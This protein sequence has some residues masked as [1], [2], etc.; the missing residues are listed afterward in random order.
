MDIAIDTT[1]SPSGSVVALNAL[2]P[3]G[4][5]VGK[6]TYTGGLQVYFS[7][8]VVDEIRVIGSRCGPF[9]PALDLLARRKVDPTRLISA[10]YT[11]SSGLAAFDD[12][13]CS[14]IMK[15]LQ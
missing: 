5:L 14:E 12:A 6:S 2:S 11:L 1:G 9:M 15:V 10:R 4:K 7:S 13:A 3:R 8:I